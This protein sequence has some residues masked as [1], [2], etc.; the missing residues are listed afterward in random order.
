M[1]FVGDGAH[2]VP[3]NHTKIN[4]NLVGRG[5]APAAKSHT[6]P[7][8]K[9]IIAPSDEGAVVALSRLG[10]RKTICFFAN[11]FSPSVFCFAKDGQC[12]FDSR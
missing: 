6:N 1:F 12:G 7:R 8:R 5:L 10:E 9:N 11:S 2:T 4:S 3:Q